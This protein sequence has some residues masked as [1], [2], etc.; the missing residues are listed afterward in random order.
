MRRQAVTGAAE[1]AFP[2]AI[3]AASTIT[4]VV[5]GVGDH[6]PINI[7]KQVE[8]GLRSFLPPSQREAITTQKLDCSQLLPP[9]TDGVNI[10]ALK[11]TTPSHSHIVIPLVWSRTRSRVSA[12]IESPPELHEYSG[13]SGQGATGAFVVHTLKIIRPLVHLIGDVLML[14]RSAAGP[15]KI[16]V[17]AA[18]IGV[19]LAAIIW[20][21][22]TLLLSLLFTFALMSAFGIVFDSLL[23]E[24]RPVPLFGSRLTAL[25]ALAGLG[26]LFYLSIRMIEMFDLP[27]DVASYIAGPARRSRL[28]Q[29]LGDVISRIEKA[30]PNAR[31]LIIG[32][33][34]GSVLVSHSVLTLPMI[35]RRRLFLITLGSPLRL[36]SRVFFPIVKTP[37][38][39]VEAYRTESTVACWLH[40]YRD[41]DII[42]RSLGL[43]ESPLFVEAGLGDGPHWNYLSDKRLWKK[44]VQLLDTGV[45]DNYAG[46]RLAWLDEALSVDEQD[47]LKALL[48]IRFVTP[49]TA[50]ASIGTLAVLL[51]FYVGV[52][53]S[54]LVLG[55]TYR[56]V[57][58]MSVLALAGSVASIV[59]WC[60]VCRAHA[61]P[62]RR[63]LQRLRFFRVP[64]LVAPT[65]AWLASAVAMGICLYAATRS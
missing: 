2:E 18:G 1:P 52:P 16:A 28:I 64:L 31:I 22:V 53:D 25:L 29:I 9:G 59:A 32:H 13:P 61:V 51:R 8:R 38:S 50:A 33:S 17:A 26:A 5:H 45:L 58:Y 55:S 37:Q 47:E 63:G 12:A 14:P 43:P 7:F 65:V 62:S 48:R 34:L 11:I 54:R 3:A 44:I 19:S 23:G 42:G 49:L 36:M 20:A 56:P 4:V 35:P 39:L 27:A 30:S 24:M 21:A 6:T 60:S 15:W 46:L 57:V 40:L 41:S 10:S